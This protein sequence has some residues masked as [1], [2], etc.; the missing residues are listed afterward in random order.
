MVNDIG[1]YFGILFIFNNTV[2]IFFNCGYCGPVYDLIDTIYSVHIQMKLML[3]FLEAKFET[4]LTLEA[5]AH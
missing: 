1:W 4:D 3:R 5:L 2:N